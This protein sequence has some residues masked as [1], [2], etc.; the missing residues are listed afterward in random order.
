MADRLCHLFWRSIAY[1]LAAS[2]GYAAAYSVHHGRELG[3][4]V[5]GGLPPRRV[6][7]YRHRHHDDDVHVA[8]LLS[9]NSI[10]GGISRI[11]RAQSNDAGDPDGPRRHVLA[12]NAGPVASSSI[13]FMFNRRCLSWFCLVPKD[14]KGVC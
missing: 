13:L 11:T 12:E 9:Y 3:V 10:A 14:E 7:V 1:A 8:D 4:G 2:H 6:A 5:A